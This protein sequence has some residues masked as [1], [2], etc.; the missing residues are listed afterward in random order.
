VDLPA[1]FM[2]DRPSIVRQRF[3]E[4]GGCFER[5][6]D[7]EK[8]PRVEPATAH[9]TIQRRPY[10]LASGYARSGMAGDERAGLRRLLQAARNYDRI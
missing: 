8:V 4:P 9:G 2:Q 6:G 1:E 5:C 7:V 10:V 3:D